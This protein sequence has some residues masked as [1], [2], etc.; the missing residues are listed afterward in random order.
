MQ[1][2][3][4]GEYGV[5]GLMHLARRRPGQRTM[6]DEVSREQKISKSFL[7]KIFQSLV[8]AGL[9][10]SIRGAGGGFALARNPAQIPVLDI[11]EAVEGRILFQ[12][13]KMARP[14]CEHVGGCALCGLFERAQDGLKDALTRT[15]L[16]DLIQQQEKIELTQPRQGR[17]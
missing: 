14:D 1:I 7:A 3:R 6:I 9:V 13:C 17:N 10:R 15:T 16:A 11:I 5:M 12:R 8:K 2:T 4:A